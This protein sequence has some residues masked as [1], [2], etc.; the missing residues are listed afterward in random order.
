MTSD[1][2]AQMKTMNDLFKRSETLDA[3]S[4][5][6]TLLDEFRELKDHGAIAAIYDTPAGRQFGTGIPLKS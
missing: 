6:E 2:R 5:F 4:I 1:H 3:Y